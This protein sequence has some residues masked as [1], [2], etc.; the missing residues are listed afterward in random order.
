MVLEADVTLARVSLVGN[1]EL[2]GRP[3]GAGGWESATGPGPFA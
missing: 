1:V 2:M 3:V